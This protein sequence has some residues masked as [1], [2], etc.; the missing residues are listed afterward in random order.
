MKNNLFK[1]L[2]LLLLLALTTFACSSK[3]SGFDKTANGLYYKIIKESKD[4]IKP[5]LGDWVSLHMSWQYK[6]SVMF[7]SRKAQG[8]SPIRFQLPAS[9]FKG[10]I[11][12]GL[13]L[14]SAGDSAVLLVN[15][16]SLFRKTFR[17]PSRPKFVD[18]NAVIT[19]HIKLLTID[20]PQN[21]MKKELEEL[22][23]YIKEKNITVPAAPSGIYFIETAAGKGMKIDTGAWVSVHFKVFLIEGKQLF[24][25]Y[26]RAEPITFEFGKHF[27]TPGVEQAI[28][29][30]KKGGK[31]TVIVPSKLAFGEAGRGGIVPPYSTMIYELEIVNVQTKAEHEKSLAAEKKAAEEK[32][33]KNKSEETANLSKYLKEKNITAKPTQSGIYY[34]EKV[35]GSG[36]KA[37][38]GKV[39][40][41]HYTGTLLNGTKFDSSR[42]RNKPF[43]F[44][45]G[46]GQ[47]I[48][49][50][51]EG[52]ALMNVGGK[53]TLIIPS[54]MGYGERDMG[55][56]PPYSTL[57][58]DVELL[59]VKD[60]KP[61]TLKK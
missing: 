20:N 8:G 39:V 59:D 31:A 32:L 23:K 29:M 36:A 6:D 50:W 30:M 61:P 56:I 60:S 41:V 1:S 37:A 45:L 2:V 35:K 13:K 25:S 48:K 12:E 58:F 7:D 44:T 27:D 24:S 52:V 15:A 57:V 47:V 5:K 54:G 51:D 43:E 33:K 19:F 46:Q 28:G 21:L 38:A 17:Q 40:S 3:Y 9:D 18:T 16:D 14:L 22:A 11:Y 53:A 49:G 26:D 55:T 34:I 10:D 4:T 42:D